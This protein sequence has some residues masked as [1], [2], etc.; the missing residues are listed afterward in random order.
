MSLL[1]LSLAAGSLWGQNQTVHRSEST[2]PTS[3]IEGWHEEDEVT[4]E[5]TWFGMSYEFRNMT[6]RQSHSI[7]VGIPI[8]Q[9]NGKK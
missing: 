1:F 7:A 6:T 8:K 9:T 2:S 5:W 4:R 3:N